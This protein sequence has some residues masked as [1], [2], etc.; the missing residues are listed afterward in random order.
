MPKPGTAVPE[1]GIY[2]REAVRAC[3]SVNHS[4]IS[5]MGC[6]AL[7]A[8]NFL[9]KFFDTGQANESENESDLRKTAPVNLS[10]FGRLLGFMH[11]LFPYGDTRGELKPKN[12]VIY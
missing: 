11:N 2:L 10:E 9:R 6:F 7:T 5:P 3:A 12:D 4:D 1:L 8:L